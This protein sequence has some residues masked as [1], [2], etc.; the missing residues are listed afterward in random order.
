MNEFSDHT[1]MLAFSL[2]SNGLKCQSDQK[3]CNKTT[4]IRWGCEKK[5]AFRRSFK[6]K[7]PDFDLIMHRN[8]ENS[9][10]SVNTC[11]NDF[12]KLINEAA[13]TLFKKSN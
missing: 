4:V 2:A 5:V 7:L 12:V 10:I 3:F 6:S 11:V 13:S 1:P 9:K 8:N